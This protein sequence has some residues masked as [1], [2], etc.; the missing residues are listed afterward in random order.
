MHEFF[1]IISS[2]KDNYKIQSI[3]TGEYVDLPKSSD[4]GGYFFHKKHRYGFLLVTNDD[5]NF[6]LEGFVDSDSVLFMT[7]KEYVDFIDYFKE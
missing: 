1:K 2:D 7:R 3:A 6:V 5:I 4:C